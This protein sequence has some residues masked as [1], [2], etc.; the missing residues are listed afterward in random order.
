MSTPYPPVPPPPGQVAPGPPR[1]TSPW[2]WILGGC[3]VLVVLGVLA[4]VATGLLVAKKAKPAGLPA[5]G[6]KKNRRSLRLGAAGE[7]LTVDGGEGPGGLLSMKTKEGSYTVGGK[8]NP[9]D[10][11]P[12]YPGAAVQAAAGGQD[13]NGTS[14]MGFFS[15]SDSLEQVLDYYENELKSN[16][17]EVTRSGA[18]A[19]TAQ[20]ADGKRML[21]VHYAASPG[22]NKVS[23]TYSSKK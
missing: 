7:E 1:K 4:V 11:V 3:G 13:S 22:G 18:G 15:T 8:W 5:D 10:W 6:L 14:G 19:L 20:D 16:G 12:A 21:S 17:M 23:I 9:P 2:L